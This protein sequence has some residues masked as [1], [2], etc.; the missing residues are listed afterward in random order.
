MPPSLLLLF[1]FRAL[2]A[3]LISTTFAPDEW[4]QGP[5]VAHVMAFGYGHLTWEWAAGLRSYAH[6]S[7]FALP[8][9]LLRLLRVDVPWAVVQVPQLVQA[10]VAAATD[11]YVVKTAMLL[12]GSAAGR[13]PLACQLAS[14][15]NAYALVRTYSNS[16]EACLTAAGVYYWLRSRTRPGGCASGSPGDQQRWLLLAALCTVFRPSSA[17]FWLL[18]AAMELARQGGR[19]A[20]GWLVVQGLAAGGACLAAATLL[21]RW[22][23]GRWVFAPWQF[24][25][26]NLVA[27]Q[28]ALYGAHPW[29]W[30]LSQGFPTVALTLLPLLLVGIASQLARSRDLTWLLGWQLLVCSLPAHKEFRFL[31]PALQ[32]AMPYCGAGAAR[33]A[34]WKAA[35][36]GVEARRPAG[37]GR[38]RVWWRHL[39]AAC[40]GLQVPAALYFCLAHHRGNVQVMHAIR[41]LATEA[42]T[43]VLFLTP[44]HATPFTTHVHAAVPMRFLDCSPPGWAAAVERLN[45]RQMGWLDL[46]AGCPAA[47]FGQE[48]S[49]RQCFE[50]EPEAYL[51]RVLAGTAP[52]RWPRVL[53]GY[54]G[55]MQRVAVLLVRHAYHRR[56]AW[57]NCWVQTDDDTPCSI[58]MKM[59]RPVL[60]PGLQPSEAKDIV[61]VWDSAWCLQADGAPGG[62]AAG[63]LVTTIH[64]GS[65]E[66]ARW[67]RA[68]PSYPHQNGEPAQVVQPVQQ[69]QRQ[70]ARG[71]GM[72]LGTWAD[73]KRVFSEHLRQEEATQEREQGGQRRGPQGDPVGSAAAGPQQQGAWQ[74]PQQQAPASSPPQRVPSSH[75][76]RRDA[77]L[78]RQQSS[79]STESDSELHA[80]WRWR[81]SR[82]WQMEQAK[83]FDPEFGKDGGDED[84]FE[85]ALKYMDAVEGLNLQMRTV[86][87]GNSLS[88]GEHSMSML[89]PS[90]SHGMLLDGSVANSLLR[91]EAGDTSATQH[92]QQIA[93]TAQHL[94]KHQQEIER[95]VSERWSAAGG[96]APGGGG[97]AAAPPPPA[98]ASAILQSVPAVQL[99]SWGNFSFVLVRL[100]DR[101]GR[102][103]LI[104]RGKNGCQEQ[105]VFRMLEQEVASQAVQHRQSSPRLELLG[106]GTMEWSRDRDRC[107]KVN[108]T[109]LHT[110]TDPRLQTVADVAF[111][112]GAVAQSS[113]ADSFLV[114]FGRRNGS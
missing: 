93:R 89:S 26:F 73:R 81:F 16:L 102:Q 44:C 82:K 5:E 25:Q 103:K 60:L 88:V 111:L 58:E 94:L 98:A 13:W 69:Q 29:H 53:V 63:S 64:I 4:W 83:Q 56:Q 66:A 114:D 80:A 27:G 99:D 76:L 7:L 72:Q 30:N 48:L 85:A 109:K 50:L 112:A 11:Q 65:E 100:T 51:A 43:S 113:L 9:A 45:A 49:Q 3:L 22:W 19:G 55:T 86:S 12:F 91:E 28:S 24:L 96:P 40:L 92:I 110:C 46:P 87:M 71:E 75:A 47:P 18:P 70:D 6:P 23:Y 97:A 74:R 17:L 38:V 90:L 35:A 21:D 33:L 1:L 62:G 39:P 15:F 107:L 59:S 32:L 20:W 42:G 95:Q 105:Q 36:R 57:L 68:G 78:H 31:L 84:D 108:G 34:S 52:A 10:A 2:N 101:Q 54:T 41:R 79:T 106:S 104:V 67:A 14:W 37:G 77:H 8:Y 61:E